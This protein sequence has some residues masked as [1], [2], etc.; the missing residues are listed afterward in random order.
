MEFND[1]WDTIINDLTEDSKKIENDLREQHDAEKRKL[2]EEIAQQQIPAVKYSS[3]LINNNYKLEQLIKNKKYQTAKLLK[4]KIDSMQEQ[5]NDEW[6]KKLY[7]QREK[8]K[9]LL[10]KKQKNE[11][12]ALKTRL[13]KSI[14]L[15]LKMRINDYD[16]LLQRIQNLQ[17][18]LIT[19]QTLQ[20]SRIQSA[21]AKILAKYDLT[22]NE[23]N[24][25]KNTSF[26]DFVDKNDKNQGQENTPANAPT[27]ANFNKKNNMKP[28]MEKD[29]K[30][31]LSE[32]QF[33]E[34]NSPKQEF[35]KLQK[36]GPR[37]FSQPIWK[38]EDQNES[39]KKRFFS[40]KIDGIDEKKSGRNPLDGQ[41]Q[42]EAFK[43]FNFHQKDHDLAK[44]NNVVISQNSQTIQ[45]TKVNPL[46]NPFYDETQQKKIEPSNII[47]THTIR[48]SSVQK[49]QNTQF[50][51]EE[52]IKIAKTSEEFEFRK[53]QGTIPNQLGHKSQNY[54]QSKNEIDDDM[55]FDE[56]LDMDDFEDHLNES[57]EPGI[58]SLLVGFIKTKKR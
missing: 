21:N 40:P 2:E 6:V 4:E 47:P 57:R 24:N 36:N 31:Q 17:N 53:E 56:S 10:L 18:E 14:N 22:L 55:S 16:K 51:A 11:Y 1:R 33:N 15:K 9:D 23:M 26:M 41:E 52:T 45:E 37:G 30:E 43:P 3:E 50:L 12:E 8:Q 48:S 34:K 46:K 58:S 44:D 49:N 42:F 7:A 54:E 35:V 27:A 38:K 29:E 20:F 32:N 19:K 25:Q 5:E 28:I 39:G 13:E